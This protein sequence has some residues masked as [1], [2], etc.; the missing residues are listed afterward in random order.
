LTRFELDFKRFSQ[1]SGGD[2]SQAIL[3]LNK[4]ALSDSPNTVEAFSSQGERINARL[5]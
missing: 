2:Y 4:S 3:N 1:G 5:D